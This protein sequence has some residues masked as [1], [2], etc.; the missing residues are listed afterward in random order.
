LRAH[1]DFSL[2]RGGTEAE[3]AGWLRKILA[4]RLGDLMRQYHGT[5]RRDVGLERELTVELD[6][7]SRLLDQGLVAKLSSPS[8]Q[9]ARR[10]QAVLLADALER[11]AP[12]YREVLIWHHLHEYSFPE[13][14]GRMGRSVDAVKKLWAR[15]LA[16]LKRSM[17]GAS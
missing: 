2:F 12:D 9:A 10:E 8:Q 6:Q 7:S 14:A 5:K 1:R 11:L 16:Q 17:G 13:V 4:A 15:A 3:L